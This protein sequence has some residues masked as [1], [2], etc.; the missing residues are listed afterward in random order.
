M[1]LTNLLTDGT[2]QYGL[3]LPETAASAFRRYFELLEERGRVMNLTAITGE[4]EVCQLHFLDSLYLLTLA[5]FQG[6]SVI[7]IGSGAGFPGLP[8]KLGCPEISLTLLD[9]QQKRVGFMAEVC[10]AVGIQAQCMHARAEEAAFTKGLRESFDFA[11]SRAVA[12]L[13]VLAELCLPFVKPGGAFIAMKGVDSDAELSEAENALSKLGGKIERCCDYTV[14]GTDV[15][16]RA[17]VIRKTQSTPQGYPR[18]FAKI[19]K[20]PL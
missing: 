2:K 9:A 5:D 13:N 11:V 14:P 10:E 12:R 1:I 16:H 4:R 20:N 3:E 7:D 8:M 18:R 15:T 17:V 6:K 19:Q